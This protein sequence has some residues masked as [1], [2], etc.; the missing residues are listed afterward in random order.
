MTHT[1]L[2]SMADYEQWAVYVR[3]ILAAYAQRRRLH[4][5]EAFRALWSTLEELHGVNITDEVVKDIESKDKVN[6]RVYGH[7]PYPKR[8]GLNRLFMSYVLGH[9]NEVLEIAKYLLKSTR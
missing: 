2:P 7:L 3:K 6:N 4:R 5:K 1:I 9:G 8:G